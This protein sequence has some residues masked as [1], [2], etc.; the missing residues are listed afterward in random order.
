MAD[1]MPAP[2]LSEAEGSDRLPGLRFLAAARKP[3]VGTYW[4]VTLAYDGF[5]GTVI[6]GE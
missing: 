1:F 3:G 2:V 6:L 4:L 5:H